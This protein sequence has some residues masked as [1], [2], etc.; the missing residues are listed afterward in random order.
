[1]SEREARK[2]AAE[3]VR[4]QNQ[5]LELSRFRNQLQR[6]RREHVQATATPHAADG[7]N[8]SGTYPRRHRNYLVPEFGKLS[9]RDLTSLTASDTGLARQRRVIDHGRAAEVGGRLET[10][11]E[12]LRRPGRKQSTGLFRVSLGEIN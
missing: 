2:I 4:P 8:D 11:S 10:E 9:L 12:R 1:V 6:I 3:Y 5:G 7:Q